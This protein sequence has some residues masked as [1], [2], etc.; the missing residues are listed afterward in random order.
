MSDVIANV[1]LNNKMLM[2]RFS[3]IDKI[4]DTLE[5]ISRVHEFDNEMR[6]KYYNKLRTE[7]TLYAVHWSTRLYFI[8]KDIPHLLEAYNLYLART[9]D[10]LKTLKELHQAWDV[11]PA[12]TTSLDPNEFA[13][14]ANLY[15]SLDEILSKY[16]CYMADLEP[17]IISYIEENKT[18]KWNSN[19]GFWYTLLYGGK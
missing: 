5:T 1:V 16:V 18:P 14:I 7:D 19:K 10:V 11:D 9:Y 15:D 3:D 13:R 8:V 4:H 12:G 6:K 2:N 17:A